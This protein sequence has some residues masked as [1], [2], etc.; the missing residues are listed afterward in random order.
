MKLLL[1]L[2]L[3]AAGL[4][5]AQGR[6]LKEN[7]RECAMWAWRLAA[8]GR[9]GRTLAFS[10]KPR[11]PSLCPT[12][13]SSLLLR[14][15]QLPGHRQLPQ[16]QHLC[17]VGRRLLQPLRRDRRLRQLGLLLRQRHRRVSLVLRC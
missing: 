16:P 10:T 17:G 6:S 13:C 12:P 2:T 7:N 3:A 9:G 5:A 14:A 15:A 4:L 11:P 1:L 8:V